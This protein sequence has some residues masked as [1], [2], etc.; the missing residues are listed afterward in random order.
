MSSKQT[1]FGALAGLKVVDLARVLGGPYCTQIMAD[2]G[3]HVIKV[4]PPQGDEVRDWGPP[5][6]EGD[7]SY[8]VG[9]NRNK[10]SIGLDL[11]KPEGREVFLRLLEDADVLID[12][13][14]TGT[15]EKWGVG[16][17]DTLAEKFPRL[18]HCRVSGY[19]EDGPLGGFPGYDAII[20]AMAGWFSING[21]TDK[22]PTRVGIAA[23]DMG[24]GLYSCVAIM[25]A[26]FERATSGRGQFID[27]TLYDCAVSMMHPHI[28]NYYLSG[29][30]VPEITGN[31][32]SNIAPYDKFPTK[33]VEV[34]IGAGNERAYGRLCN[35]LGRPDLIDDPRFTSN[36]LRVANRT[37]LRDELL[38]AFAA[39]DGEELCLK[40]LAAGIPAGPVLN[41]A[42]VMTA[43]HTQHRNMAAKLDWYE[44]AGTPIKFSRTPGELR[45]TPPHF[46]AQ[47]DDIL[48]EHGYGP[49]DIDALAKAG[50]LVRERRKL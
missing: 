30:K 2:H 24:T 43:P 46:G 13:Y 7:A 45:S 42:Q 34:F 12:N 19:G 8:F 21:G 41:T 22:E 9:L 11:S 28:P 38:P 31:Q 37:D 26:L 3:A 29:G 39:V 33:T 15:L 27:M 36:S 10:R 49:D 4:E 50:A 23:V 47:A 5:F 17:K 35:E 6:H 32:H 25:M 20:Q 14:K 48:T 18:I 1:P 40:L 16:Y 44:G